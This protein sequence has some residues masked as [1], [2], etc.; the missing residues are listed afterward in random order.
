MTKIKQKKKIKIIEW[1]KGSIG[2]VGLG[3]L[4]SPSLQLSTKMA[5]L[6][7]G[8]NQMAHQGPPKKIKNKKGDEEKNKI[9]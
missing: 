7:S 8:S 9:K 2:D 6:K 5:A 4:T 1:E 3:T